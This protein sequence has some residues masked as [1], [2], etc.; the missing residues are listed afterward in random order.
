M[1]FA[2][3]RNSQSFPVLR[4]SKLAKQMEAAEDHH[5]EMENLIARCQSNLKPESGFCKTPDQCN[6]KI[7]KF[8]YEYR[9]IKDSNARSGSGRKVWKFY[10]ATNSERGVMISFRR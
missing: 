2:F 6:H 5:P 10:D 3:V 4:Y 1:Q 7:N 8:K 9:K